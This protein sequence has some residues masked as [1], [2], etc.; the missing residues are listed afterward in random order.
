MGEGVKPMKWIGEGIKMDFF[1]QTKPFDY[2]F[3]A[4]L[5]GEKAF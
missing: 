1:Q 2:L 4:L 3:F 5:Q